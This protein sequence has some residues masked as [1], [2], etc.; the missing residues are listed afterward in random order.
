M[1]EDVVKI[2]TIIKEDLEG[3]ETI[4]EYI[5]IL[6][7][8]E[9][10]KDYEEKNLNVISN[11]K[12]LLEFFWKNE[13]KYEQLTK[14]PLYTKETDLD[15]L[16]NALKL[17]TDLNQRSMQTPAEEESRRTKQ[18]EE[19]RDRVNELKGK[20]DAKKAQLEKINFELSEEKTIADKKMNDL[21]NN[22]TNMETESNFKLK[23]LEKKFKSDLESLQQKHEKEKNEKDKELEKKDK[24][25]KAAK[26]KILKKETS[27]INEYYD[28]LSTHKR[29]IQTYDTDMEKQQ[30]TFTQLE[31]EYRQLIRT[32]EELL[33]LKARQKEEEEWKKKVDQEYN[34]KQNQLIRERKEKEQAAE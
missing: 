8:T 26:Q 34:Q 10:K 24:D 7:E 17:M 23:D 27:T 11:C 22:M 16:F 3:I 20:W 2:C 14:N 6:E 1:P 9:E 19:I 12:K 33:Q 29:N 15:R 4:M 32:K 21:A 25:I 31:T 18:V 28:G 13:E 30:L 5:N